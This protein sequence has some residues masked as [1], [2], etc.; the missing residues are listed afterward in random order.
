M[1]KR[2]N[3]PCLPDCLARLEDISDDEVT[4]TNTYCGMGFLFDDPRCRATVEGIQKDIKTVFPEFTATRTAT[5]QKPIFIFATERKP[6][7]YSK[8]EEESWRQVAEVRNGQVIFNLDNL[9]R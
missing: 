2:F 8:W 6:P 3:L 9:R 7:S 5:G 4:D 1:E